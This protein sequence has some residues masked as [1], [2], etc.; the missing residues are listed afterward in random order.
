MRV[1]A[2]TGS[3]GSGATPSTTTHHPERFSNL[4]A[5]K[6]F[7]H[8]H[9]PEVQSFLGH[10]GKTPALD[11]V[12]LSAPID[13]GIFATLFADVAINVDVDE[14][15][16]QA[17]SGKPLVRLRHGSPDLRTLRGTAMADISIHQDNTTVAVLVAID[18]LGKGAAAQAIQALNISLGFSETEGLLIPACSP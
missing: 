2:A 18:N 14:L 16:Q 11:F 8:Q 6:V 1:C 10:L 9:V 5:Y 15:F 4:R 17:Y 7:Q 12:P 3:T 13:R